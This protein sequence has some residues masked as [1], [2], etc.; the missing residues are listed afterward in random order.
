M[1]GKIDASEIRCYE[2]DDSY[3]CE[4]ETRDGETWGTRDIKSVSLAR[5]TVVDDP[6]MTKMPVSLGIDRTYDFEAHLS[7]GT[8]CTI[9]EDKIRCMMKD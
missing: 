7:T 3:S 5:G 1:Q 4:I 6:A 8:A 9:T 2:L